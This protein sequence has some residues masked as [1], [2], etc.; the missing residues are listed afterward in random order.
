MF[1]KKAGMRVWID[2]YRY[3]C[4]IFCDITN[5]YLGIFL[6]YIKRGCGFL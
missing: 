1:S 5:A 3:V 2:R 4:I 6:L